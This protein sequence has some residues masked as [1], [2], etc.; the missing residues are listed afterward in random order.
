MAISKITA[1]DLEGKG[2]MPLDDI[3]RL[4]A[5]DMKEKFE[6]IVRAVVIV[7]VNEIIEEVNE[8]IDGG[9][10]STVVEKINSTQKMVAPAYSSSAVYAVGDYATAL[11]KLYRC[12]TEIL[13]PENFN[14]EHWQ[15]TDAGAEILSVIENVS[16]NTEDIE[17]LQEDVGDIQEDVT[18]MQGRITS[19]HAFSTDSGITISTAKVM[20]VRAGLSTSIMMTVPVKF[21]VQEMTLPKLLFSASEIVSISLV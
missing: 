17:G 19:Y 6:E 5:E 12:T 13:T 7:K 10:Q 8:I 3:P 1:N 4:S 20:R 15:A 21:R 9:G 11:D 2:V 18:D 16:D 14:L